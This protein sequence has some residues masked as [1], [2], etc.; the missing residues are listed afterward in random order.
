MCGRYTL[1]VDP[2]TLK[3]RFHIE[4]FNMEYKP[5][6]NIAPG[7]N[8]P[9]IGERDNQRSVFPMRW[10]LIPR[11][12]KD[13]SLSYKMINARAETIKAKPA[14]K[15][16][17]KSRRCLIPA[18]SFYEWKNENGGKQPYR[19]TLKDKD[20]FAFA[21]VWDLWISPNNEN[22]YSCSIITTKANSFMEDLH[23]RMPV[24]ITGD[25]QQRKWLATQADE[26]EELLLP[27]EGDMSCYP[28]DKLVNSPKNDMPQ[29]IERI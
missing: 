8:I 5:R 26:L 1:T 15:N 28:V 19:I 3:K 29:C 7:Q 21:G 2:E 4:H 18:D 11:W 16:S 14:F 17:F 23:Q 12:A 25:E 6:Y 27:Y 24:I 10:G 22:V 9:V 13:S 20:E